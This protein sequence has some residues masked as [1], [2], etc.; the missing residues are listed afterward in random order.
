M[1]GCEA[2]LVTQGRP[3]CSRGDHNPSSSACENG[4][5]EDQSLSGRQKALRRS[6]NSFTPPDVSFELLEPSGFTRIEGSQILFKHG[7]SVCP[8]VRGRRRN[9]SILP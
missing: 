5:A 8:L 7:T 2:F 1:R 6:D 4:K 3:R 9:P